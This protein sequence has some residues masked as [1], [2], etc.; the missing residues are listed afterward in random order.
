VISR[1]ERR[2]LRRIGER[3]SSEAYTAR[4]FHRDEVDAVLALEADG[5]RCPSTFDGG[6]YL[7]EET[8][9]WRAAARALRSPT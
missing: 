3:Q 1:G 7:R 6:A 5:V 8:D 4:E 9:A 2:D